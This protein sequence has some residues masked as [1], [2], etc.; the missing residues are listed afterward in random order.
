MDFEVRPFDVEEVVDGDAPAVATVN[1][2][3]KVEAALEAGPMA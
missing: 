3:R 2:R 1:A